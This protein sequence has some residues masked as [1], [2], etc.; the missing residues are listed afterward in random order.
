MVQK[1]GAVFVV[2]QDLQVL[3]GHAGRA[4]RRASPAA[5]QVLQQA[6]IAILAQANTTVQNVLKLLQ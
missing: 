4:R 6:S 1:V 2:E 5:A 3:R